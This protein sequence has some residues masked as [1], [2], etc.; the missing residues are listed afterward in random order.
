MNN[1]QIAQVNMFIRIKLFFAKYAA[2]LTPFAPLAALITKFTTLQT[3]LQTEIDAQGIDITGVA[4]SKENLNHTMVQLLVPLAR[5]AKVWAKTTA[6]TTLQVQLD[7]TASDFQG[8]EVEEVA[9]AQNL[10]TIIQANAAALLAYNITAAQIAAAATAVAAFAGAVGTPQQMAI[11]SQTASINIGASIKQIAD[12]L[13]D[14]DDLIE[15]EFAAAHSDMVK[16]YISNRKIG[17]T[18][19]LHT[20]ITAHVYVDAAHTQT[21]A[22]ATIA[23][24]E[25]NRTDT[26]KADGSASIVQFK[27]GDYHLTVKA[28]GHS[29]VT[30]PFSV[31]AGKHIEVDVVMNP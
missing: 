14:C 10:L 29:D 12:V 6:N 22:G 5:K 31:K 3:A 19:A 25:L 17:N 23:I 4:K 16:E 9:L 26:T 21:I 2:T 27:A 30:M 20:T 15:P 1:R 28:T 8:S 13:N 24:D 7:V 18:T 11:V